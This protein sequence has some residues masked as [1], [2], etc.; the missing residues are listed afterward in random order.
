MHISYKID[1]IKSSIYWISIVFD[2]FNWKIVRSHPT[3]E[4]LF[5]TNPLPQKPIPLRPERYTAPRPIHTLFSRIII[6]EQRGYETWSLS[7]F[8]DGGSSGS[9]RFR[10]CHCRCFRRRGPYSLWTLVLCALPGGNFGLVPLLQDF[11][12]ACDVYFGC[13]SRRIVLLCAECTFSSEFLSI[14]ALG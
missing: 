8:R 6:Y 2:K 5:Y 7:D 11:L 3:S 12:V 1:I 10:G 4:I 9:Q 13:D 14:N